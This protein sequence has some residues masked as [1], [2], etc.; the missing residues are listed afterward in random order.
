MRDIEQETELALLLRRGSWLY[1]QSGDFDEIVCEQS[2]HSHEVEQHVED[3]MA[4]EMPCG[5][6]ALDQERKGIILVG[7]RL[8]HAPVVALEQLEEGRIARQVRSQCDRID[9]VS[10]DALELGPGPS[11]CRRA[12]Q[13][14]VLRG[15]PMQE[16][17]E[18]GQQQGV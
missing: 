2:G 6:E 3:V 15:V 5:A 8:E 7:E 14:V 1:A 10:H 16:H 4:A 13:N 11:P 17:L 12:D 18:R 9:A